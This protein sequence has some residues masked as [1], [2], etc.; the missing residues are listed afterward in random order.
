MIYIPNNIGVRDGLANAVPLVAQAVVQMLSGQ[1]N[2]QSR[3]IN[4]RI[5]VPNKPG[6]T[7]HEVFD[8]KGEKGEKE[9]LVPVRYALQ[10]KTN[11]SRIVGDTQETISNDD[12][13]KCVGET[14][15]S[16][17]FSDI[18]IQ[19]T[20]SD[21]NVE[22]TVASRTN[23]GDGIST[24][25]GKPVETRIFGGEGSKSVNSDGN[26]EEVASC[27][28]AHVETTQRM[29]SSAE[30]KP[31][32]N[33][34]VVHAEST[35]RVPSSVEDEPVSNETTSQFVGKPLETD[36]PVENAPNPITSESPSLIK[37]PDDVLSGGVLE[38][39]KKTVSYGPQDTQLTEVKTF[40]A[41]S[42]KVIKINQT[43]EAKNAPSDNECVLV[44]SSGG[45][46][47]FTS[48]P[49][50]EEVASTDEECV[51]IFPQSDTSEGTDVEKT[52]V[53]VSQSKTVGLKYRPRS[54]NKLIKRSGKL[55]NAPSLVVCFIY[56]TI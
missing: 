20:T 38:K 9:P 44:L 1:E 18:G 21:E 33:E 25:P 10:Q 52:P 41:E 53:K 27:S 4:Y 17:V 48:D 29:S 45:A 13:I 55:L 34:S 47:T 6:A 28:T 30:E 3:A 26:T 37:N 32:S 35:K 12:V 15:K 8:D 36:V 50:D 24:K 51:V 40:T 7:I 39:P 31:A 43:A 54:A 16:R 46:S 42:Q 23:H 49:I 14:H 11:V 19:S 5:R 56:F 2:T 22:T